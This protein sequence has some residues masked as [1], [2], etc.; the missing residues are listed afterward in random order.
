MSARFTIRMAGVTWTGE[1]DYDVHTHGL[2]ITRCEL[3]AFEATDGT[4][5]LPFIE[6]DPS[7]LTR[8]QYEAIYDACWA[9]YNEDAE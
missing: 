4:V 9:H 7:E 8:E 5:G 6:I 1:A 2:D 3:V